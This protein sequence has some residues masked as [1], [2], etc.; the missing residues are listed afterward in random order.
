[1]VHR[2]GDKFNTKF[3]DLLNEDYSFI[4]PPG[5]AD[6]YRRA[7]FATTLMGTRK[8]HQYNLPEFKV[9]RIP[10]RQRCPAKVFKAG[11]ATVITS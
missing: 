3:D 10:H 2:T 4:L 6:D 7:L 11:S 5:T 9:C 1:M 8:A